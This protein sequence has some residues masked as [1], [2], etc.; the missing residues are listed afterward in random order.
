MGLQSMKPFWWQ[1]KDT[2]SGP[3]SGP[4]PRK[5][6]LLNTQNE[7]LPMSEERCCSLV[8]AG[9]LCFDLSKRSLHLAL[10]FNQSRAINRWKELGD[11]H[12]LSAITLLYKCVFEIAM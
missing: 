2:G 1:E 7:S 11:A 5:A 10:E 4:L 6:P 9:N 3:C 8:E 12:P